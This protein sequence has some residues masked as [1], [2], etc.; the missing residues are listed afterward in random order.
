MDAGKNNKS[1][2]IKE[3]STGGT[4]ATSTMPSMT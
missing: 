3:G 4:A 2:N 1:S